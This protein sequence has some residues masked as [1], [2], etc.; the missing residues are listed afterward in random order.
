MIKQIRGKMG[1]VVFR[2]SPTGK[3]TIMKLPDMSRAK[4][5]KAQKEHRQRFKQAVAYARRRWPKGT[6][7]RSMKNGGEKAQTPVRHGSLRLL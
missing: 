2:V 5:S 6:C 3:Q 1:N 7:V 4:W